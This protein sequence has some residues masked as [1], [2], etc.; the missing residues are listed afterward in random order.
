MIRAIEVSLTAKR[1]M[2]EL[3]GRDPLRGFRL[4]K[5][6]LNPN[7]KAL[8]ERLNHRAAAMFAAGLVEEARGLLAQYGPV[9]AL[10]SLGYR[11]A[12]AV[13]AGELSEQA[14]IE[15]AQ[16]AHRNFAKRQ[17]T[18]FRR[19]HDV[20][21]LDGFGDEA[22]SLEAASALVRAALEGELRV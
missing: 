12:L 7:R 22:Q 1:P 8:Y 10:D 13:A 4:L 15:A 9:K 6:G 20:R 11:Q 14:G 19:E 18:W 16:Q 5:V 21:W 3:M 2:S 17:L